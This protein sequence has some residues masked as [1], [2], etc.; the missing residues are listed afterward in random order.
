MLAFVPNRQTAR[1][2]TRDLS[3]PVF[4]FGIDMP[5]EVAGFERAWFDDWAISRHVSEEES[6][7]LAVEVN[8]LGIIIAMLRV[9]H[10]WQ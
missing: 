2:V 5:I 8:A 7:R 3:L 9:H 1:E 4:Q 6:L 10:A